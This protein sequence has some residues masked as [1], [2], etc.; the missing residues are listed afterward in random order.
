M[1]AADT[2]DAMVSSA[3]LALWRQFKLSS[4]SSAVESR[5]GKKR[6]GRLVTDRRKRYSSAFPRLHVKRL[7]LLVWDTRDKI[8]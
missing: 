6:R 3:F 7:T 5:K 4:R 1:S 8:L 2:D